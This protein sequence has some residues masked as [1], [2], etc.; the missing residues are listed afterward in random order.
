MMAE[1]KQLAVR[2]KA[3]RA[4]S[5]G[6]YGAPRVHDGQGVGVLG[7][8]HAVRVMVGPRESDC[9]CLRGRWACG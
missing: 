7:A 3:V 1:A 9:P 5:K 4:E 2:V 8:G 6:R